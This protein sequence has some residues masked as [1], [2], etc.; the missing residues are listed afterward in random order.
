MK[1]T[2]TQQKDILIEF[3][4]RFKEEINLILKENGF[5]YK[6]RNKDTRISNIHSY[7]FHY[8]PKVEICIYDNKQDYYY[9]DFDNISYMNQ[10][11]NKNEMINQFEDFGD[12]IDKFTKFVEN[13]KNA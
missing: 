2:Q 8:S 4:K 3:N 13:V 6:L 9:F 12:Y 1:L 11:Y 7:H 10:N 5:Y